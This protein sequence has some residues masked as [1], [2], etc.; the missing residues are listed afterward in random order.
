[1]VGDNQEGPV[2]QKLTGVPGG[3]RGNCLIL[4]RLTKE[5]S[6]PGLGKMEMAGDLNKG[7]Q[8]R[9]RNTSNWRELEELVLRRGGSVRNA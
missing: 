3:G 9:D 6:D 1:M 8:W 2:S 5:K 7:A 4:P